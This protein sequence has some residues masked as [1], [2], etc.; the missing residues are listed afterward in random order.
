MQPSDTDEAKPVAQNGKLPN[1][2]GNS[3]TVNG[4]STHEPV[5]EKAVV[6]VAPVPEEIPLKPLKRAD[7]KREKQRRISFRGK[8][9]S[10]SI[11]QRY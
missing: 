7:S 3:T 2:N 4:K 9:S 1:A 11:P 10:M 8:P 5:I 6:E